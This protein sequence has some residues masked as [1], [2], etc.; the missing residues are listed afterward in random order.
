MQLINYSDKSFV[1]FGEETKT[2]KD[3]IKSLGGSWNGGLTNPITGGKFRGW[4]FS[5]K[6]LNAVL[7]ILGK[8]IIQL[9]EEELPLPYAPYE[10]EP[11]TPVLPVVKP[12]KSYVVSNMAF[13]CFV[14]MLCYIIG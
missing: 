4:I 3:L 13:L 5:N 12:V 9:P 6:R 14:F 11:S 8:Y 7:N 1:L 10:D 2:H